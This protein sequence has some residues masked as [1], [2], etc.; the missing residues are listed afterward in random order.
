MILEMGARPGARGTGRVRGT[1]GDK[2]L[3]RRSHFR[4]NDTATHL[5]AQ[6]RGI[7]PSPRVTDPVQDRW[8]TTGCG[9]VEA[10]CKTLVTERLKQSG[11]RWSIR[12]GQAILTLRSLMQRERWDRAWGLLARSYT[13]R[14]R[15]AEPKQRRA[16]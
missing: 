3:D 15:P 16:A 11:M 12:G 14:I 5:R 2:A 10:A 1:S 6:A 4:S 8:T 13:A 9:V 7:N